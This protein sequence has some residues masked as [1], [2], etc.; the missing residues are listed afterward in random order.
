[1]FQIAAL[2]MTTL[3]RM[4]FDFDTFN[5][6]IRTSQGEAILDYFGLPKSWQVE[7]RRFVSNKMIEEF[8]LE[9]RISSDCSSTR[10]AGSSTKSSG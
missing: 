5:A 2:D 10:A 4:V 6:T 9:V 8:T 7:C 1:M 3:K